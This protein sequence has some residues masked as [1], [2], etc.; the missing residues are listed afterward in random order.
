M[1]GCQT[2]IQLTMALEQISGRRRIGFQ[3][4]RDH[5]TLRNQLRRIV[6]MVTRRIPRVRG[7]GRVVLLLDRFLTQVND[8]RSYEAVAA[9]N[10]GSRLLLDLRSREQKFAFYYGVL[11]PD[12]IVATKQ[13]FQQGTFYDIGASIGLYTV[14]FGRICRDRG[15]LVRSIEPVPQ[16]LERLR[17]QL[18]LNGLS[19][20]VV[21]IDEVAL[22]DT[23]GV[24]EMYLTDADIP[25][26]AKV[27]DYGN[28]QV[29]LT[30]LDLLWREHGCESIGFIKIDTEGW[31][32]KI[33]LGGREAISSCRPNMLVE[34]NRE[35]MQIY[36]IPIEPCWKFLV[37]D[38]GYRAYRITSAGGLVPVTSPD[39]A[40][41]LLFLAGSP[42]IARS[43][44]ALASVPTSIAN[45]DGVAHAD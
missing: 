28:V 16:N 15:C 22:G 32:A 25:G 21:E 7:L 24:A 5:V 20:S 23:E 38:L 39:M 33:I 41:Y 27:A 43:R 12:F 36:N 30:T 29:R 42:A 2:D 11:E 37:D 3:I 8:P 40:Q 34:F 35:R 1:I 44:S 18:L 31:D 13:N 14:A 19:Q 6:S 4:E 9:V 10:D 45:G 17:A 26:N